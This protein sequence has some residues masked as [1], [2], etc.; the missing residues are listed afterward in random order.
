MIFMSNTKARKKGGIY[1]I[2]VAIAAIMLISI[3]SLILSVRRVDYDISIANYK[4]EIYDDLKSIDTFGQLRNLALRNESESIKNFL[5]TCK[6]VNC[7]V[8]IFDKEKNLTEGL[9]ED[10]TRKNVASISYLIYGYIG[11]YSPR[12][13]RVYFWME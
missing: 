13:I 4:L 10:Y 9:G 1:T 7:K 2:E 8:V 12:E 5:R 3:I 11:E 6:K